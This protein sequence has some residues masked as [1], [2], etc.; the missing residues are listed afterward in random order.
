M[1]RNCKRL[2]SGILAILL[3]QSI[4]PMGSA[5]AAATG[6]DLG[7]MSIEELLEIEVTSVSKRPQKVSE[8]PAAIT[9]L[10]GEDIRR[11]GVTSVPEALRMVPGIH[12]AQIDGNKWAITSRGFN[13]QFANKLLVLIDGRSVYTPLFSGVFWD[14]QDVM[15]EDVD[16]IEVVRGPGGTLWGANAVNG[17]I[18][19]ITK[20]AAE[21]Q[22][23]LVSIG[24]GSV[25][26]YFTQ[27]RIGGK[28]GENTHY[29]VYAKYFTREDL[30]DEPGGAANDDW[31]MTRGGFR[32]DWDAHTGDSLTFQGDYYGGDENEVLKGPTG[33]VP[34]GEKVSGGNLL[35]RW[36]HEFE[37]GSAAHLQVYYDRVQRKVDSII[38]ADRD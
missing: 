11:S 7:L 16:R 9:V 33:P 35:T 34:G 25:E 22:G 2:G 36:D 4:A 37:D 28:L 20:S 5:R 31:S 10:T 38:R 29:R 27:A 17:V 23:S 30:A 3:I 19:I 8:A 12:V 1:T 6:R 14:I 15:L 21:T 24:S 18:N 26:R 32:M 13:D